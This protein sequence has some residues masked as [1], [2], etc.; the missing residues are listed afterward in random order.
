MCFLL[1]PS[2][3]KLTSSKLN[4]LTVLDK[5]H[6]SHHPPR[7]EKLLYTEVCCGT[8]RGETCCQIV[9][10]GKIGYEVFFCQTFSRGP[11]IN[12]TDSI[13]SEWK[14]L[15]LLRSEP[16]PNIYIYSN[17]G[18]ASQFTPLHPSGE[19]FGFNNPFMHRRAVTC[20]NTQ[21]TITFLCSSVTQVTRR[22]NPRERPK[23]DNT[24][25]HVC[26]NPNPIQELPWL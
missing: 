2:H 18:G 21:I 9:R 20:L 16:A 8:S 7:W 1:V 11:L 25:K 15:R 10:R 22:A 19:G 14:H 13:F 23:P 24:R 5:K 3:I 26:G 6:L 4:G 17:H 12:V